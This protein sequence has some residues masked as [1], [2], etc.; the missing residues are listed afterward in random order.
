MSRIRCPYFLSPACWP[1]RLSL[2]PVKHLQFFE[3][4][5]TGCNFQ[6]FCLCSSL[7]WADSS[8]LAFPLNCCSLTRPQ[9]SN[10]LYEVS[11]IYFFTTVIWLK[12]QGWSPIQSC[13]VIWF[14]WI[15]VFV[16]NSGS[17]ALFRSWRN[18]KIFSL[19]KFIYTLKFYKKCQEVHG[20]HKASSFPGFKSQW[21]VAVLFNTVATGHV[22]PF[23]LVKFQ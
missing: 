11:L 20:P 2:F 6:I 17:Q 12:R 3:P 14:L 21:S 18:L 9:H 8:Y 15:L 13:L 5:N 22:W 1:S 23:K 7:Y 10:S 4:F 19:G 16:N